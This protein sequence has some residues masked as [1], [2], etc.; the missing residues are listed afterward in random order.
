MISCHHSGSLN[1]PE[2]EEY[3]DRGQNQYSFTNMILS[4]LLISVEKICKWK[5]FNSVEGVPPTFLKLNDAESLCRTVVSYKFF[6][7]CVGC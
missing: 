2:V 6:Y 3:P 4:L 1:S 7:L 5:I